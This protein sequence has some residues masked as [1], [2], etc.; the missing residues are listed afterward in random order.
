MLGD[1]VEL[2]QCPFIPKLIIFCYDYDVY[3]DEPITIQNQWS[4]GT[5]TTV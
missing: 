2:V 5:V 4:T 1:D 3:I